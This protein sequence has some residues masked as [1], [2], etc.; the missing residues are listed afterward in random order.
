[1]RSLVFLIAMFLYLLFF[2]GCGVGPHLQLPNAGPTG[3][4]PASPSGERMLTYKKDAQPVFQQWCA[5]CHNPQSSAAQPNWLDYNVAVAKKDRI[6]ERVWVLKNMPPQGGMP[7]DQR[8]I[9]AQWITQ[10]AREE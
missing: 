9:I 3:S 4:G 8:A 1:M 5:A 7:D 10:G 6:Y 2:V